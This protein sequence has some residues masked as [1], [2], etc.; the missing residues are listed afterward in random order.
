M[1]HPVTEAHA[2]VPESAVPH[3][4]RSGWL[5]LSEYQ[6]NQAQATAREATAAKTPAKEK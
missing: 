4:R 2:Q 3:L 1:Y 5:L 6:E